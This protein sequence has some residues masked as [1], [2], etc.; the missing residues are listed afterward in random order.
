M[1]A[2]SR[3]KKHISMDRVKKMHEEKYQRQLLSEK[4]EEKRQNKIQEI[5]Q[6]E[7]MDW[8]SELSRT[9]FETVLE[10][11]TREEVVVED[12]IQ[13]RTWRKE[14]HND[15]KAHNI[16]EGMTSQ[17]MFF[18]TLPATG[19]QVNYQI[20]VNTADSFD[21]AFS[22][23]GDNF[24]PPGQS[25]FVPYDYTINSKE[26]NGAVSDE[27]GFT[28][29]VPFNVSSRGAGAHT[30][31]ANDYYQTSNVFQVTNDTITFNAIAG[32]STTG[33]SGSG[34]GMNG[35]TQPYKDLL[36]EYLEL[37][38][39]G[40]Y[41][42]FGSLGV[43]P[44]NT[45][46]LTKFSF[47]IPEELYGKNIQI[48]LYTDTNTGG[49]VA[50]SWWYQQDLPWHP[51]DIY[52]YG[53]A[54]D[55]HM[56]LNYYNLNPAS[57]WTQYDRT[58]IAYFLWSDLQEQY[59]GQSDWGYNQENN[60]P[61]WPAPVSGSR[62][63]L[64]YDVGGNTGMTMADLNYIIDW[65]ESNY[66]AYKG[67]TT[68]TYGITNLQFQRR[69]PKNVFVSLDS[70]EATSFIRTDPTMRG[71]S[72]KQRRKKLEEML[73]AGDKYM[74][75]QLGFSGTQTQIADTG[76]VIPW[77]QAA[78]EPGLM[79]KGLE[80]QT[81]GPMAPMPIQ[82]Q[83]PGGNMP[84][85]PA[86]ELLDPDR[87]DTTLAS[88]ATN[89]M[90]TGD[91]AAAAAAL[92]A[93][94]M[95]QAAAAKGLAALAALVGGTGLAKQIMNQINNTGGADWGAAPGMDKVGD[96]N[97]N[98][99]LG[100]TLTPQQQA[101]VEAAGNELRDAQR[102]LRDL[103][104]DATDAQKDMAREKVDRASKNRQRL[105]K[106]HREENKN[107][108]ESFNTK[109]EVILEKKKL[110]SV[111]DIAK[112]IPGYY[113]GKPSPTGFPMEPPPKLVKLQ[114]PEL[115]SGERAAKRFNKLDPASA[116]AMPKTAYPHIDKKVQAAAKKPK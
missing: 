114:H 59:T 91:Q 96:W 85:P 45:H 18:T 84:T 94:P 67:Y 23:A 62:Y 108:K 54:L 101:D 42:S 11:V 111:K 7:A 97:K 76:D 39:N 3:S 38:D 90:G 4:K 81:D 27:N 47:G 95:V 22:G 63:N 48:L 12:K 72:P 60:S 14:L 30:F 99:D 113:D 31:S 71:L 13:P 82:Q 58:T 78:G 40:N 86:D 64:G 87:D 83:P 9:K 116:K 50:Y 115:A 17:G 8:R 2:F 21:P 28:F 56:L 69:Q 15:V 43:V 66:G 10:E 44:R 89:P 93:S 33:S 52:D 57:G 65:F 16:Q 88:D 49:N 34:L 98:Q 53:V 68:T 1:N 24:P 46:T 92:L 51:L 77:E 25:Y 36:V 29:K 74:L 109:G 55:A 102:A 32:N 100:K 35:G 70:P 61:G 105:R 110:K 6:S 80:K 75:Q 106:K 73:K 103:P 112:K 37:D 5:V 79:Q 26:F 107:R 20:D 19:D 41:V 104:A